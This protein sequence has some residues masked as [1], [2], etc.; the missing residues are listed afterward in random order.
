[1]TR[2][3]LEGRWPLSPQTISFNKDNQLID[4]STG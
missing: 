3:M 2:D 1:M 4:D